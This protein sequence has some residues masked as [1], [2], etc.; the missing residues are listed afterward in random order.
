VTRNAFLVEA[1]ASTEIFG[2]NGDKSKENRLTTK[3]E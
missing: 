3:K 2:G 1:Q